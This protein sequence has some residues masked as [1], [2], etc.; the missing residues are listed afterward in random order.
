MDLIAIYFHK[1]IS[2]GLLLQASYRAPL[3][4]HMAHRTGA[5]V[6]GAHQAARDWP[7]AVV[8]VKTCSST[9]RAFLLNKV[10]FPTYWSRS[11]NVT[12]GRT[13]RQTRCE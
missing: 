3:L 7:Q 13:Y 10:T 4:A 5:Q 12:D 6:H 8:T 11:S 1:H 9:A 2:I